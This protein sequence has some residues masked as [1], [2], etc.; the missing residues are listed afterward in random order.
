MKGITGEIL[1]T[2]GKVVSGN[3]SGR[4]LLRLKSSAKVDVGDLLVSID[5]K[6]KEKFFLKVV[7]LGISSLIPGQ[8]VEEMAGQ[9]LEHNSE[10]HTFDSTDRFYRICETKVLKIERD[11]K[12]FPPRSIPNFF[13]N[14][15]L[16]AEKELD[17]INSTGEIPIGNLRLGAQVVGNMIL[18]LPAKSLISHHMLVVA[19]TGKG[20]SNFSKVFLSGLMELDNYSGIVFDPH[21]EYYGSSGSKG[22]RD[23]SSSEKIL[24]FSPNFIDFP[25]AEQLRVYT[26]DLEPEDFIG[27]IDLSSA[28]Q[29]ALDLAR[30][31]YLKEWIKTLLERDTDEIAADFGE[32]V[33]KSTIATLKRKL[34]HSLEIDGEEGLVF[35]VKPRK[36]VSI[37]EKVENAVS[38]RK[39]VIFDT[40]MVGE[41]SEKIISSSVVGRV[42][43]KYRVSKQKKPSDFNNYPEILI[44]FEEAP[45][46]LGYEVLNKGSNIFERIA[47]EGRKFKVGLCAITQM[48]SLLSRE[49]LSQMN[50]KVILGLP[51]PADREAVINSSSQN[52]ADESTEVQ[53]LD[54]GEAIITSPFIEFPLPVKIFDFNERVKHNKKKTPLPEIGI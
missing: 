22:L 26:E 1:E 42:F 31:I 54:R 48:P 12:R 18:S 27:I 36:E 7:N 15:Y 20:K 13:S 46:V 29:E 4:I 34:F 37:Y 14:V 28:Q 33:H 6:I 30:R 41:D 43:E 10:L 47:R 49:I 3:V 32:R 45:R 51:A 21:N 25:G 11:G 50:T 9:N 38:E 2:I 19:A 8:F 40:S 23:H 44:L 52:I 35:S 17:F 24:Y 39:L 53:M 5:E 16:I